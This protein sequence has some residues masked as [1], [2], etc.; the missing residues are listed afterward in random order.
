MVYVWGYKTSD[1]LAV[2]YISYLI[3]VVGSTEGVSELVGSAVH[4][5]AAIWSLQSVVNQGRSAAGLVGH[6]ELQV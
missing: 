3:K 1:R 6:L 2:G 4:L 5:T